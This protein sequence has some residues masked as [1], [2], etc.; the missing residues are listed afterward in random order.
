MEYI[1]SIISKVPPKA[2]IV[3]VTSTKSAKAL[4]TYK[5]PIV[6]GILKLPSP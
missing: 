4:E 1:L 5:S 3:I 6:Q 2:K